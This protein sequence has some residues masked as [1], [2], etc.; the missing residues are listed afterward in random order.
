MQYKRLLFPHSN[1]PVTLEICIRSSM[2][3]IEVYQV[4]KS[5]NIPLYPPKLDAGSAGGPGKHSCRFS[6]FAQII[7]M[8]ARI[9]PLNSYISSIFS[10]AAKKK[11]PFLALHS[12]RCES[13]D[14]HGQHFGESFFVLR[15]TCVGRCCKHAKESGVS[16]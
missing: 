3:C 14:N 10:L 4:G 12:L 2:H 16:K 11:Y 15:Q 9:C 6:H 8:H 7:F 5:N 13:S 1:L